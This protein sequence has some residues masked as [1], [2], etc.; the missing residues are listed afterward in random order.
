MVVYPHLGAWYGIGE[1]VKKGSSA[2]SVLNL[3]E[4]LFKMFIHSISSDLQGN[5]VAAAPI[6]TNRDSVLLLHLWD[7]LTDGRRHE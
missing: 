6:V 4:R 5:P 7:D 3:T 2:K 1:N